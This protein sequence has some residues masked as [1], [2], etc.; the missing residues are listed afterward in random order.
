M[1]RWS[2][3]IVSEDRFWINAHALIISFSSA[4]W[5]SDASILK[6]THSIISMHTAQEIPCN[7]GL[8][9]MYSPKF[10]CMLTYHPSLY[11]LYQPLKTTLILPVP[12]INDD[13]LCRVSHI[14][15]LHYISIFLSSVLWLFSSFINSTV[16]T[17]NMYHT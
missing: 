10:S 7:W 16:K 9:C 12:T 17:L 4:N 2:L 6:Q 11:F 1:I 8:I 15:S 3:N 13:P 14:A 5:A